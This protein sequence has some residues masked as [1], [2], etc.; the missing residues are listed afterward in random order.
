MFEPDNNIDLGNGFGNKI[1]TQ[2]FGGEVGIMFDGR[3]KDSSGN[4]IIKNQEMLINWYKNLKVYN[5]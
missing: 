1:E 2:V 5:L 4:I 3:L